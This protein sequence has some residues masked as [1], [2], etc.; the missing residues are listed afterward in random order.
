MRLIFK[1]CIVSCFIFQPVIFAQTLEAKIDKLLNEKFKPEG[2]G[3]AFLAAKE[4]K[5]I[6]KKA[7]GKANLELNV[8]MQPDF[9]FEIGSM[10][11][12]FTAVSILMLVEQG[13]L[14]LD[15]EITK[16]IPDY[17]TNGNSITIHHL[18]IHTSGIK[19]FTSMKAIKDIAKSDLSP[20]ELVDFFKNE[21]VDFK[22]GEQYKYCNSGYVLL[23]YIIEMVSGKTFGEFIDENIFKKIDMNNTYY[24]SHEKV[25]K[26][27]ASGYRDR[28]GYVNAPYISFSIPYASG[29]I[30]SN[31]EDLL[32]W[33]NAIAAHTLLSLATTAKVFTNYQLNNGTKTDYGYGWHIDA[34]KGKLVY[35][36]G[37]SIFGFKSMG[38]YEPASKIYVIGLS[39]CDCNSPTALTREIAALLLD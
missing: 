12:Q 4:G 10:T 7:F 3:G 13:K 37:G 19:D 18:L 35:E 11:K 26:N 28:E 14:K 1:I 20:K 21:P 9:V 27:R 16:F 30:I 22:P 8:A 15:D 17:P 23:G 38:V 36:H 33:Q 24:A 6:Y 5:I 39:N 31:V 32:K 25:I 2:P 34:V 29:S